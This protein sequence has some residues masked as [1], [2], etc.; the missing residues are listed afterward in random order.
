MKSIVTVLLVLAFVALALET[1]FVIVEAKFKHSWLLP[2]GLA[3]FVGAFLAP[4][5][6]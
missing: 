3:L 5:V 2:L 4:R 6:L 1:V